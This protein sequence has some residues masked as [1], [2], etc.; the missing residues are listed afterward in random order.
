LESI[1][2]FASAFKLIKYYKTQD[3]AYEGKSAVG[4]LRMSALSVPYLLF[5]GMF[6][7]SIF[8]KA[9]CRF[10]WTVPGR[11]N[12]ADYIDEAHIDISIIVILLF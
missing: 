2:E 6:R 12:V 9:L 11:M 3:S 4:P 5:D 10:R 7:P 8:S 1:S